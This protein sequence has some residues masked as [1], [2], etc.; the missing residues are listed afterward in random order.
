MFMKEK[1]H[2]CVDI[3]SMS[4]YLKQFQADNPVILF[5]S[6]IL[7]NLICWLM[8]IFIIDETL[9]MKLIQLIH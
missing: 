8:K 7:K 2:F 4:L 6:K 9:L 3:A 1:L 5:V